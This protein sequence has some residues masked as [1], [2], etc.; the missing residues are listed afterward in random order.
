MYLGYEGL[1]RGYDPGS[2]ES[3]ECGI[4]TDGSC[5]AFDRLIGSRVAVGN[6]ELRFP[7]LG[8]FNSGRSYYGKL[9]IEMAL[10]A[11]AGIAWGETTSSTFAFG[12]RDWV[13]SVGAAAR[14]NLFGF[15]I[16]EVAYVKPLDR[17]RGW[18]WQFSLRPGF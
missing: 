5:P 1:V 15:A 11:D 2:F 4:Q 9:P 17:G 12:D 16:G 6:A 3:G 13:K 10:F 8:L 7:L 18:L 14:M